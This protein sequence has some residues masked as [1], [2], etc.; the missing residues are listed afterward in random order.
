MGKPPEYNS[1]AALKGRCF[2]EDNPGYPDYGGRGITVCERWMGP[3]GF[4][5]FYAD[6]GP[7]P[8]QRYTIER[9]DNDLGYSPENCVWDTKR[10]QSRNRRSVRYVTVGGETLCVKDWGFRL[11]VSAQ[12]LYPIATAG[13]DLAPIFAEMMAQRAAGIAARVE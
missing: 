6:M 11:G 5:N 13:F 1:W 10:V 3:D 12:S 2:N 9:K 7:K 4:A 8:K